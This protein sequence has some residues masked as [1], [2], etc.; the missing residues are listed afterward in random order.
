MSD[1]TY[2]VRVREVIERTYTIR[3]GSLTEAQHRAEVAVVAG[4][5]PEGAVGKSK[6]P[7]RV[8]V[9]GYPTRIYEKANA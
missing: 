4:K 2:Q 6:G 9:T 7:D 1:R 8:R 5:R 3:A